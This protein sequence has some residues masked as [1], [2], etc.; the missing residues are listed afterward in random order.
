MNFPGGARHQAGWE[1]SLGVH[2]ASL[3]SWLG[4]FKHLCSATQ[5]VG[6]GLKL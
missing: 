5:G 2:V 6:G 4:P 3:T 1:H